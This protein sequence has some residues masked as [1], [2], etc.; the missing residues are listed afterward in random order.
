MQQ[1]TRC[2]VLTNQAYSKMVA[3]DYLSSKGISLFEWSKGVKENRRADVLSIYVMS[4]ITS[5]HVI[6]HLNDNVNWS[7]LKNVPTTHQE[8]LQ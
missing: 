2:Y 6:I 7:T 4:V 1:W 5:T 3:K 8:I